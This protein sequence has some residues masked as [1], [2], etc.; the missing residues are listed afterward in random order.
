MQSMLLESRFSPE[1]GSEEESSWIQFTSFNLDHVQARE[2][3]GMTRRY[4]C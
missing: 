3:Q 4:L 1:G 2:G